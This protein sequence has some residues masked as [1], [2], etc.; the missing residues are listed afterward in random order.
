M[1]SKIN[2]P[3]LDIFRIILAMMTF[4]FHTSYHLKISFGKLDHFINI[5]HISM[6]GFFMLSGFLL[7]LSNKNKDLSDVNDIFHFYKKRILEILPAYLFFTIFFMIF[8]CGDSFKDVIILLPVELI[9]FQS[10]FHSLT[11]YFHN[12]G[13]WFISCMFICYIVFPL[14][15]TIFKQLSDK[16]RIIMFTSIY[17]ILVYAVIVEH[18]FLTEDIYRSCFFRVLEFSLG[19]LLCSL[20]PFLTKKLNVSNIKCFYSFFIFFVYIAILSVT[21]CITGSNNAMFYNFINIPFYALLITISLNFK[22]KINRYLLVFSKITLEFYL[23]QFF[24]FD[25]IK[26][27][28]TR[29]DIQ[30]NLLL[31]AISFVVSLVISL[32]FYKTLYFLKKR[33]FKNEG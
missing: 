2:Y 5:S 7:Y 11:S 25:I 16:A 28:S 21:H 26:T 18:Y 13:S 1:T 20:I 17:F 27:I 30:S 29:I 23:A 24:S 19:S 32:F 12:S 14:I 9:G 3:G 15:L 6:T 31:I 10:V 22:S 4:L 33:I 8:K